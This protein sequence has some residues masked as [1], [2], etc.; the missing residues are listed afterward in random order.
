MKTFI[1]GKD[2]WI[3]SSGI[4]GRSFSFKTFDLEAESG[5]EGLLDSFLK[6][7]SQNVRGRI[8][9]FQ[10]FS[11]KCPLSFARSK[12]VQEIGFLRAL[13]LIHFEHKAKISFREALKKDF[14]KK[15][16]FLTKRLSEI[17]ES[18]DEGFLNR[19][20]ARPFSASCFAD[21]YSLHTPLEITSLGLKSAKSL[22][23]VLKLKN[24]GNYPLSL[25][26]LALALEQAPKP[27]GF[28]IAFEKMSPAQGE[29][30]L[31]SKSREEAEGRGQ[32]SFEKYQNTQKAL[33]DV[34]LTGEELFH[35]EA[36]LSL[37][38]LS[39][40]RLRRDMAES[41]KALSPLG[42]WSF[43]SFGAYPSLSA[44]SPGGRLHYR[45][46]EKSSVLKCF[47]PCFR[48]G[49]EFV[50][51]RESGS[52]KSQENNNE[53]SRLPAA[54]RSFVY[55]RRDFSLDSLNPFSLDYSN[56]TGVII[57][58][59]GRGK[60]VFAN[61]LTR[62]LFHDE[63]ASI[64]LVDVRGSHKKTVRDLGGRIC[65]IDI[66]NSSGLNPMKNLNPSKESI[67]ILS[68]FIEKLCLEEGELSLP[69]DERT[70]LENELV[71]FSNR[72][73]EKTLDGF[74]K[75]SRHS[76]K[77][78]LA[79]WIKG[80]LNESIFSP[81]ED[82]VEN[83]LVYFNF[84]NIGTASNSHIAKAVIS[85]VMAEF[86]FKLINKQADEKFI[87]TADETP[88]FIKNCFNTFSLL[89]KN[90]R[91]LNGSLILIAQNSKDLI[92]NHDT[93]LIDNS[94]FKI[95]FSYDGEE[96]GFREAF[97][98]TKEEFQILK[99]IRT[100]K[101]RFS[102]FLLK[103][104][105]GSKVG[106]LRLSRDEYILSNTEPEF[107]HKIQKLQ[108]LLSIPERKALEVMRYV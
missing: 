87:L 31:K 61:L 37:P 40:A 25:K 84:E 99:N 95:L 75:A 91:K 76:R 54:T 55:H 5:F 38:R 17:Y 94:E 93:S 105:L 59:S 23:G 92:L 35:Y 7:L 71:K 63:K 48:F 30:I 80:S 41:L 69:M 43:E 77:K 33:S 3:A 82:I 8:S 19:I 13:G 97:S 102:Q 86:S 28:H 20:E 27:L 56:H 14:L 74:Y 52:G 78:K 98:L 29:K 103:D 16:E 32:V 81:K 107:L 15:Q 53:K 49:A 2:Y 62:S 83:R 6:S 57:G 34:E 47:F 9:L 67:E 64:F 44:L 100:E 58:K 22:L 101:G 66:E 21:L 46:M 18:L 39:E 45:L 79:R 88:F 65:N 11:R 60:S 10:E 68:H 90:V 96:R 50:G 26:S 89:S 12:A 70:D 108:A 104:S 24:S 73:G 51:D 85:A 72:G 42:E 106:F 36:H 4:L 1:E